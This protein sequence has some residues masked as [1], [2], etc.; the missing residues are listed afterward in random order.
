[1]QFLSLDIYNGKYLDFLDSLKSQ[2]RKTLVFTPNPEMLLRA[3]RDS[4]FLDILRQA[5]ALTPD[6]NG[7]YTAS[8][9]QEGSSFLSAC[10]Q[11][12]F[13]RKWLRAKYGELIQ[14]SNLTRDLVTH[15]VESGKRILMIDNY[16]ITEP[17]NPFEVEKKQVQSN[18]RELFRERFPTLDI[19][20]FF[21]GEESPQELAAYIR[22]QDIS[23]VFSCIGMKTQE[24][25]LIEIFA[26]LPEDFPVVGLGVGSSFDY[27]L[28][29]QKRAPIFVQK[30]GLEW[31][32]RLALSP[33]ARWHRI[34]DAFYRFPRMIQDTP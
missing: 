24:Q 4:E 12:F 21:D 3:G 16:R 28:G 20:V 14:G 29:L 18:L 7:L 9:I 25:R 17:Q 33:R 11:T 31:L 8:L 22:E 10:F 34:V 13:M 6:A 19:A 27:L 15:A 30:L 2:K 23:Y 5:D 1:M 26:H 32:Y